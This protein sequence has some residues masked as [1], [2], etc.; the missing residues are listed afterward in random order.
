MEK[1]LGYKI[2]Y[3]RKIYNFDFAHFFIGVI[4]SFL[5]LPF[6]HRKFFQKYIFSLLMKNI[7][8]NKKN[9]FLSK[10]TWNTKKMLGINLVICI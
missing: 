8:K 3:F 5:F 9:L 10:T 7:I 2:V 1:M 6:L 4:S